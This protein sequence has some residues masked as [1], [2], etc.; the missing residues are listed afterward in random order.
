MSALIKNNDYYG[1]AL[2]DYEAVMF[3]INSGQINNL[4]CSS[5]QNCVERFLKHIIDK[6][7]DFVDDE[8]KTMK[9]REILNTH[10]IRKIILYLENNGIT[11]FDFQTMMLVNGY[12][13]EARYPGS[14]SIFVNKIDVENCKKALISCKNDVDAFIAKMKA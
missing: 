1:Y 11:D 12:Y 13:F 9:K 3:M 14:D 8:I 5:A 7:I 10:S 2:E 6:Y 4:I